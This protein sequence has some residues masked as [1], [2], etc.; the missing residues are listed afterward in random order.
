MTER[1]NPARREDLI[2]RFIEALEK[3]PHA[4]DANLGGEKLAEE[5]IKGAKK[6]YE[7]IY[8]TNLD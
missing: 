4:I 5:V 6:L 1:D 8:T 3:C 2:K 7:F